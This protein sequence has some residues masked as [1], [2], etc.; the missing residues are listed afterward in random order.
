MR[1]KR[2]FSLVELLVVISIVFTIAVFALPNLRRTLSIFRVKGSAEGIAAQLNLARQQAIGQSKPV[3]VFIDPS[4]SRI[5]VDINRNGIPQ[6][7]RNSF[8]Q[9]RGAL[10]EEY[11]IAPSIT[12]QV[13]G[14]SGCFTVPTS[15]TGIGNITS[16]SPS[17]TAPELGISNYN[18][19]YAIVFDSR[20]EL[21]LDY[22]Q[23]NNTCINTN[24]AAN[25][26]GAVLIRCK[27]VSLNIQYTISISIR[28]GVSILTY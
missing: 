2:G 24:L 26:A 17:V 13:A 10:N 3:I 4:N 19:W 1:N 9:N 28:G 11:P 12:L 21:Q 25:P 18:G 6:G 7:P 23:A 20:G 8:V 16:P 15:V 14:N 5:F 27:Q 22:R